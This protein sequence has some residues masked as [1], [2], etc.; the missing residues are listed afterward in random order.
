MDQ[1]KRDE[2]GEA[3]AAGRPHLRI[4]EAA[5]ADAALIVRLTLAAYEEYRG[6]LVPA[7][8]VF[9]ETE[10]EVRRHL[11][12][13]GGNAPRAGGSA[14]HPGGDAHPG[15]ALIAELDGDAVGCARWSVHE[16]AAPWLYVGRLSVL[17]AFRGQGIG[18]ALMAACEELARR[19][20]MD[21]VRLG[22]RLT[23]ERN[24]ALYERLGYRRT[25]RTFE[26][27]GYGPIAVWMSKR[28][29]RTA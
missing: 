23:L 29:G 9:D 8:T 25:G 4:R 6:T 27:E 10:D 7:S 20:A 19:R 2:A 12:G 17:P 14:A 3:M 18:T 26:R 22:V 16:D 1:A 11:S 28:V 15:G 5:I 21:E 13:T 24:E